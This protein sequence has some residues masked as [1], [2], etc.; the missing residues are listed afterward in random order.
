MT[1]FQMDDLVIVETKCET[2]GVEGKAPTF[3]AILD[4]KDSI[5]SQMIADQGYADILCIDCA[6]TATEK[7]TQ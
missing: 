2:C 1:Q 3:Q 4:N 6:A 7:H 5:L